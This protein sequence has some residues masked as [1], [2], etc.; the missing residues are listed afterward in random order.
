MLYI[1]RNNESIEITLAQPII[2]MNESYII[3]TKK[4]VYGSNELCFVNSR[5]RD[6]IFESVN[7]KRYN[8]ALL[9]SNLQKCMRRKKYTECMSTAY[10]L[11]KQDTTEF[12]RRLP[13]ILLEDSMYHSSFSEIIW[14]M[15]AHSKGYKLTYDD[16]NILLKSIM[17]GLEAPN[18]YDTSMVPISMEQT[19]ED[20][21]IFPYIRH[22]YGG[23]KGDIDFLERMA[24]CL[25]NKQL[26]IYTNKTTMVITDNINDFDPK[27]HIIKYA[28]DFH[29]CPETLTIMNKEAMWWLWSSI[30]VRQTINKKHE[31]YE[32]EMRSKFA[33]IFN[34]TK[35]RLINY[36]NYMILLTTSES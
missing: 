14:L 1:I 30:N 35:N 4:S 36:S 9:K 10:Q 8:T 12:L 20:C 6:D 24:Y 16:V 28:I 17:Y 23:M 25:A 34:R 18:R 33:P 21:F 7:I 19:L 15:V 27:K 5:H 29:C 13:I 3:K 32:E 11:I 2:N 31:E 22:L 26:P